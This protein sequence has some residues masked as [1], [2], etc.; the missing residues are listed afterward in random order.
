MG[1]YGQKDFKEIMG[2][3]GQY[4]IADEGSF[5]V[6]QCNLLQKFGTNISPLKLNQF[7]DGKGTYARINGTVR[8]DLFWDSVTEF[9]SSLVILGMDSGWPSTDLAIVKFQYQSVQEPYV[10]KGG[11]PIPNV[12]THFCAMADH[13]KNLIIDS[14]DGEVKEAGVYGIPVS[15]TIYGK[16]TRQQE[17]AKSQPFNKFY[18]VLQGGESA[19]EIARKL[20]TPAIELI[21]HNDFEDSEHIPGGSKIRLP[22]PIPVA[23]QAEVT[24]EVFDNPRPMH[25]SI[26]GG[27]RKFLF[28]NV[29]EWA[30]LRFTG[31]L[32][33]QNASLNIIAIARVPVGEEIASYYMEAS[34]L[35]DFYNTGRVNLTV[36]FNHSHLSDGHIEQPEIPVQPIVMER[37]IEVVEEKLEAI[38]EPE[39]INYDAWKET[40]KAFE[41]GD[42][43]SI[44]KGNLTIHDLDDRHPPRYKEYPDEIVTTGTFTGPDGL[45]YERPPRSPTSYHWYGIP[46]NMLE[47]ESEVYNTN[48][49]L[50]EKVAARL[51]LSLPEK[52]FEVFARNVMGVRRLKVGYNKFRGKK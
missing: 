42:K 7:Y 31:S 14:Y 21:E 16:K 4:T 47:P 23:E 36:G 50:Y 29:K 27:T 18:T 40:Y 38:K 32:L 2:I 46:S 12:I 34:A 43:L 45:E 13:T 10:D 26:E 51:P 28:G 5:L 15:Y 33:K 39:P 25:V 30:D 8:D 44:L 6:A 24:Y 49:E 22:Y 17:R 9:D 11:E 37:L 19:W 41:T 3:D 1:Y 35:G 52:T 20:K 48:L